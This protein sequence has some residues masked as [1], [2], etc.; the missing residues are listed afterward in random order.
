MLTE[1]VR[2]AVVVLKA[3][4]KRVA[5]ICAKALGYMVIASQVLDA[6]IGFVRQVI[7][8]LSGL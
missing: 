2:V 5:D 6:A 4:P 7:A 1:L 8:A 3:N